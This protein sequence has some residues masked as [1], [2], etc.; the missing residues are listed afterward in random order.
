MSR[1]WIVIGAVLLPLVILGGILL[2]KRPA[3][4]EYVTATARIGRLEQT[5]EAVGTVISEQELQLRFPQSGVVEKVL[6]NEGQQVKSGDTLATLRSESQKASIDADRAFV[7]S[8]EAEL[9]GLQAGTRRE[10][11]A[12]AESEVRSREAALLVAQT[13]LQSAEN[14]LRLGE[15]SLRRTQQELSIRGEGTVDSA[16][17]TLRSALFAAEDA[18]NELDRAARREDSRFIDDELREVEDTVDDLRRSVDRAFDQEEV[19]DALH[20]AEQSVR[21]IIRSLERAADDVND[22]SSRN[23]LLSARSRL[24]TSVSSI[25]NASVEL[26]NTSA[27][28]STQ[29]AREEEQVGSLRS[30]R[31]RAQAEIRTAQAAVDTARAQL[32]RQR[33]GTRKSDIDAAAARVAQAKANLERT[34]AQLKDAILTSPVDGFVTRIFLKEGELAPTAGPGIT[35]L[36]AFPLRVE[37]FVSEIDLPKLKPSQEG[38]VELDAFPGREIPLRLTEVS[39]SPTDIEGVTKYRV[40]LDFTE[41]QADAR[42]GMSGDVRVITGERTDVITVPG[43]AVT[44]TATGSFVRILAADGSVQNIPVQTGLEGEGGDLE[45]TSGLR[46]GETVILLEKGS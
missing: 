8:L 35:L 3:T 33:A 29:L 25:T 2:A 46:G 17:A 27:N 12:V 18:E 7:A 26:S 14:Q 42:V 15:E 1:R 34:E 43:R 24:E 20:D 10:D 40:V 41:P 32:A 6:V 45:I 9:R 21:R 28:L 31:D 11:I 44:K 36:G 23:A 30:A 13:S 19:E 38:T 5:V 39:A 37:M 4:P 22:A 16:R